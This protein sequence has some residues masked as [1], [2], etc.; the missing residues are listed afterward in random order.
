MECQYRTSNLNLV[1]VPEKNNEKP[2]ETQIIFRDV[3]ERKMKCGYARQVKLE[4][5]HRVGKK[6]NEQTVQC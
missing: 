5:C 2:H 3:V 6:V 4:R 1:N